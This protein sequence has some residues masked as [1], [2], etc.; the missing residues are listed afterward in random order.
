MIYAEPC[1]DF[2]VWIFFFWF[3]KRINSE[4]LIPLNAWE[5]TFIAYI[6]IS[7][8]KWIFNSFHSHKY[9]VLRVPPIY[10]NKQHIHTTIPF[11]CGMEKAGKRFRYYVHCRLNL[12]LNHPRLNIPILFNCTKFRWLSTNAIRAAVC[13]RELSDAISTYLCRH[14]YSPTIR[15]AR[16]YITCYISRRL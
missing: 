15:K 3:H 7:Y 12:R 11:R 14:Q 5:W 9:G 4:H 8:F 1:H 13:V 10:S 16:Q 6:Y 2:M